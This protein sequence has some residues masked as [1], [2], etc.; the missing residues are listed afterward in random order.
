MKGTTA[1]ALLFAASLS[2]AASGVA[3]AAI[4]PDATFENHDGNAHMDIESVTVTNDAT[5]LYFTV[6]LRGSVAA[7]NDWG[8]YVAGIDVTAGGN[9]TGNPWARAITMPGM[10]FWIGSWVDGAGGSEL[11]KWNGAAWLNTTSAGLVRGTDT[12]DYTIPLAT[13]GVGDGSIVNFDFYTTGGGSG[14]GANDASSNP[15]Q[16]SSGWSSPYNSSVVSSYQV[17]VPEPASIG[18]AALGAFLLTRR[19]RS[20]RQIA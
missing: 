2:I 14:D 10:D 1:L 6:D 3:S 11:W 7:P 18:L 4:Y 20:R 9:S 17:V 19:H 13:L 12:L 8:K 15:A 16:A 5:N